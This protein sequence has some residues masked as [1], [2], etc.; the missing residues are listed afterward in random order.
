MH[1]NPWIW[2][3]S[4]RDLPSNL[5]LLHSSFLVR[6]SACERPNLAEWMNILSILLQIP[7]IPFLS[8]L[9]T[10]T[11]SGPAHSMSIKF[12]ILSLNFSHS[13]PPAQSLTYLASCPSYFQVK[14]SHWFILLAGRDLFHD[15]C[16]LK[17]LK[18]SRYRFQ[19]KYLKCQTRQNKAEQSRFSIAPGWQMG[20][21]SSGSG[22]LKTVRKAVTSG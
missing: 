19:I 22:S 21:V 1:S 15:F 17:S 6:I 14:I 7:S 11:I 5:H 10:P 18:F 16:L 20:M 12:L 9:I 13:N 4:C 8:L 3:S 2:P